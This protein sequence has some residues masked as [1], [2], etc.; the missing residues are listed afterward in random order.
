[1]KNAF[2][3]RL[4]QQE[5]EENRVTPH[6]ENDPESALPKPKKPN[7][8]NETSECAASSRL[9]R[10]GV[11]AMNRYEGTNSSKKVTQDHEIVR[12]IRKGADDQHEVSSIFTMRLGFYCLP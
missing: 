12:K 6:H 8:Q 1:M 3:N 2:S 7:D 10:S 9:L 5:I 4:N 11:P